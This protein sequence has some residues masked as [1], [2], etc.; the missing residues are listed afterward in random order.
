MGKG[1]K[2]PHIEKPSE[3]QIISVLQ[4]RDP[5]ISQ[6]YLDT[7]KLILENLPDIVYSIDCQDG[8]MGYGA[9]Q[10]GYDGWGMMALSAHSKWVSLVFMGGTDLEDPNG[11]LEG[12]G[13]NIRH[14]KLRSPEQAKERRSALEELIR[15]ASKLHD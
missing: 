15:A 6:L 2:H 7:H 1:E 9:R 12:I 14:V 5:M 10:Y 13:K 4:G 3:E 11:L 8:Q